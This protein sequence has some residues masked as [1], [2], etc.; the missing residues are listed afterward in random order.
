M[1]TID[2]LPRLTSSTDATTILIPVQETVGVTRVTKSAFLSDLVTAFGY[3]YNGSQGDQGLTGYT[4]SASTEAGYTGSQG[5]GFT[6]SRGYTG[7][8]STQLGYIGSRGYTGSIGTGFTGSI[9]YYGSSGYVG[10]IGFTGSASTELGYTGST[11]FTGS[12]STNIGYTGSYGY[13]GSIGYVGSTGF[14]G[15]IGFTGSASTTVGYTGSKGDT[16]STPQL[17]TVR[18]ATWVA[19]GGAI[20]TPANDVPILIGSTCTISEITIITQGGTG[21]CTIDLWKAP[22]SSYPPTI[23]NSICGGNYPAI[24]SGIKFQD[25]TLTSWNTSLSQNDILIF[26]LTTSSVFTQIAVQLR[27]N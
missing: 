11:G 14:V 9:G 27:L 22:Y 21:S 16:G 8:G 24:N 6:G 4:G 7:S 13:A 2:S 15:S 5:T 18:G 25:N 19:T 17:N 23:S 26:H 10:S 12:A 20:T 3:G 1:P